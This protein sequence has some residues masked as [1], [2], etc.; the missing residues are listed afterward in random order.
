MPKVPGVNKTQTTE[1]TKPESGSSLSA[2]TKLSKPGTSASL[3]KTKSNDDLLAGMASGGGVTMTNG[4]K[5]K[6]EHVCINSVFNYRD[7][8]E[9]SGK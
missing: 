6:K 1:K 3:L 8:H 2:V 4:V 5:A 9:H 7:N